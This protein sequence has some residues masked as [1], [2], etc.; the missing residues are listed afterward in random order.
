MKEYPE[1]IHH[2][3]STADWQTAQEK[4]AYRAESLDTEG[5]I[6]FS[7]ADQVQGTANRYYQGVQDLVLLKIEISKV[8]GKGGVVL[9]QLKW[10]K[11]GEDIF[12]H[13][14]GPLNLDA[15]VEV[16]EFLPEA[17]GSFIY[18]KQ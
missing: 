18:P 9:L 11:S 6:H 15:V 5:F 3:C 16:E 12:P 2:I 1:F 17:D 14:Y 7:R 4:D 8:S 10:E 13:L